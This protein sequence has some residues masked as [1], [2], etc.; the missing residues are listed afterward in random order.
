[1]SLNVICQLSISRNLSL[2][3]IGTVLSVAM[4]TAL[5]LPLQWGGTTKPWSSPQV[6]AL[7]PV[8]AVLVAAFVAWE[9]R[10]GSL[11][12]MP[13]SMF[14]RRTQIGACLE[15]VGFPSYLPQARY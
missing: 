15:A 2:D 6:Y 8:F 12:I 4:T 7:F 5:L 13:L 3:W 9:R 1:V 10:L 11:A 14:S